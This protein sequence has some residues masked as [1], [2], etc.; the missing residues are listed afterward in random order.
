MGQKMPALNQHDQP[1]SQSAVLSALLGSDWLSGEDFESEPLGDTEE[2]N[3]APS[4]AKANK[5]KKP[6]AKAKTQAK[7]V[8]WA[9]AAKPAYDSS[10]AANFLNQR[11]ELIEGIYLNMPNDV[12]HSLNALSSTGV[13]TFIESP[14]EY[15]REY[16]SDI[17]RKKTTAQRDTFDT[18][19]YIHELCLEPEGF[20]DRYFRDV[21]PADLPDAINTIAQM[22]AELA[23]LGL[24]A[25]EGKDEKL[26]RL[27]RHAPKTITAALK[28]IKDID[29][30]LERLGLSKTES[31]LDK[32]IRLRAAN[33]CIEIFDLI[34]HERRLKHGKPTTVVIEDQEVTLYGGKRP[35]C[36]VIWDDAQ[37]AMNTVR[38]HREADAYLQ[39][40]L[41]EVTIIVRCPRTGMMLKAKFDWLRF[42]NMACDVK[43]TRDTK[44]SKFKHQMEDLNYPTQQ[45]FYKYTA[46]LMGIEIETFVF[47]AVE[48]IKADI[49]QPYELSAKRSHLAR[50]ELMK[51]LDNFVQCRDSNR[52]YGWSKEDCTMVLD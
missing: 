35:I 27:L 2:E 22:D 39:N 40:G 32:A 43:S 3:T 11:G 37:R 42:D 13:K 28:T 17:S 10:G 12:Y 5:A 14:A 15:Y 44:P 30:E 50:V 1:S 19:T 24:P 49:C 21:V 36:G 48:F 52:W 25:G 51:A 8:T 29:A 23:K 45:E 16:L 34:Q 18:G 7:P 26:Q 47:I 41:A 46:S 33:P 20:N 4:S 9:E 38:N 6:S 31:K